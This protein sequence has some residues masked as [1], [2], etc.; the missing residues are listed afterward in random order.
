MNR[1]RL[2][3]KAVV[4][5]ITLIGEGCG[6]VEQESISAKNAINVLSFRLFFITL[7][8]FIKHYEPTTIVIIVSKV[9]NPLFM[10]VTKIIG[11]ID[12]DGN[13]SVFEERPSL[14]LHFRILSEI[15]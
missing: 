6:E 12:E 14:L 4:P 2:K 10:L 7:V 3:S 13:L 9:N 1:A 5:D 15:P 8:C 11:A